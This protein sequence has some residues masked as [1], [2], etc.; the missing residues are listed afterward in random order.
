MQLDGF[1]FRLSDDSEIYVVPKE[2]TASC[3]ATHDHF[4][5]SIDVP[6][7]SFKA[8]PTNPSANALGILEF[9]KAKFEVPEGGL[10]TDDDAGNVGVLWC[11]ASGCCCNCGA[12][13]ICG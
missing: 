12:G 8:R 5:L 13:W 2:G 1:A 7:G 9:K 10:R 4:E 11:R 6:N 3:T